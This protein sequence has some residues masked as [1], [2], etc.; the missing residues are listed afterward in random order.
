MDIYL[1]DTDQYAVLGSTDN[2]SQIGLNLSSGRLTA[3]RPR[4]K[5]EDA[6]ITTFSIDLAE[7]GSADIDVTREFC[8]TS[9]NRE[10]RTCF[11]MTPDERRQYCEAMAAELLP[12]AKLKETKQDF[13]QYPGKIGFKFKIDNFARIVGHGELMFELPGRKNLI[14]VI[15]AI[16]NDRRTPALRGRGIRKVI[17]YR[18]KMPK[19][20]RMERGR[21]S[22]VELGRRNSSYFTE[23]TNVMRDRISIDDRLVLPV[24]LIQPCDYV[25]LVDLQSDIARHFLRRIVLSNESLRR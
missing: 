11:E 1:N 8:G 3:I 7:N 14:D 23:H 2:A 12:E 4:H 25:E 20:Y 18:I 16:E 10:K 21:P 22:R 15:A 24:E 5:A 17:K 19:G 13:S 9:F 6:T